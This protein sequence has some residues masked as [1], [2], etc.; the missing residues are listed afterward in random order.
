MKPSRDITADRFLAAAYTDAVGRRWD[1]TLLDRLLSEPPIRERVSNLY[2]DA[3]DDEREEG[4]D[5][6]PITV[7]K[8]LKQGI[9]REEVVALYLLLVVRY[10]DRLELSGGTR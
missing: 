4:F 2:R 9:K 3:F 6:H 7:W 1:V 5:F 10:R 8:L